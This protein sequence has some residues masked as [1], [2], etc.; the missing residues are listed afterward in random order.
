MNP[1]RNAMRNIGGWLEYAALAWC[2]ALPLTLTA[3]AVLQAHDCS[4]RS[5]C[6]VLP[7]N[8]DV[9]TGIA[10]GGAGAALGWWWLFKKPKEEEDKAEECAQLGQQCEESRQAAD[11]AEKAA[12][13]ARNKA[14]EA[15][16]PCAEARK[17]REAAEKALAELDDSYLDKSWA[18]SEGR[19]ITRRDLKLK[20]EASSAVF[21]RYRRGEITAQQLEEEWKRLDTPEALEELRKKDEA[22]RADRK[23]EAERKLADA[24]DKEQQVCGDSDNELETAAKKAEDEARDARQKAEA[25]CKA[26]AE[27]DQGLGTDGPSE[28]KPPTPPPAPEPPPPTPAPPEP[29]KPQPPGPEPP[30]P[31]PAP[32]PPPPESQ[33]PKD[34]PEP[35]APADPCASFKKNLDRAKDDL[36][37]VTQS[38][39]RA[40][41][42]CY[43]DALPRLEDAENKRN[44]LWQD[45]E[46]ATKAARNHSRIYIFLDLAS[47]EW[48]EVDRLTD[49][50]NSALSTFSAAKDQYETAER[51]V[52]RYEGSWDQAWQSLCDARG[53]LVDCQNTTGPLIEQ[54]D[55]LK[56]Q[57]KG[58]SP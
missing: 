18:E 6:A 27:C 29:P 5:D 36:D 12:K 35:K 38:R 23:A 44:K 31:P 49:R 25:D 22:T 52:L 57:L 34:D 21:E 13:E 24:K 55:N 28:P 33:P 45:L 19:R 7:P 9:A 8:V 32:E 53:N 50:Y 40:R 43:K 47:S 10:A 4:D 2:M 26:A 1:R 54:I 20:R 30:A 48:A 37:R 3:A 58:G 15:N 16:K 14:D 11:E 51:D 39:Q 17:A 42:R 46:A 56:K 41:L